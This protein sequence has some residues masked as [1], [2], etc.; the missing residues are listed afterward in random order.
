MEMIGKVKNMKSYL[1][2][3]YLLDAVNKSRGVQV[4]TFY[5]NK[6]ACLMTAPL[7]FFASLLNL[8]IGYVLLEI[9]IAEVTAVSL[10]LLGLGILFFVFLFLRMKVQVETYLLTGVYALWFIFMFAHLYQILGPSIWTF[11]CLQ[12]AFAMNRIKKIIGY[13]LSG[14][15]LG[16][17]IYFIFYPPEFAFQIGILYYLPQ[18]IAL[19]MMFI[20]LTIMHISNTSRYYSLQNQFDTL[21]RQKRDIYKLYEDVTYKEE[22]LQEQNEQLLSFM[23][24]IKKRD[25][26]L[27]NLAFYDFLTGLPNRRMFLEK[28]NQCLDEHHDGD[29]FY[30]VYIDIDSFKR[31]N[32]T[33][34]HQI[35]DD[36]IYY[37]AERLKKIIHQEDILGRLGGDEFAL[38]VKRPLSE[39]ELLAEIE[40]VRE[41]F[42]QPIAI[43]NKE[44]WS[45]ASFGISVFPRDGK[46]ASLLLRCADMSMY[47]AKELGKNK[48]EFFQPYMQEEIEAK[49]RIESH[50]LNA[51]EKNEFYLVFQ[52]QYTI[53]KEKIRGIEALLRWRSSDLG[54]IPPAQFIPIAEENRLIIP[55]GEWVLRTACEKFKNYQER[56]HLDYHISVNVSTIQ[57]TDRNFVEIVKRVLQETGLDPRYLELEITESV[58]I[59]SMKNAVQTLLD[60]KELGIKIALDDFGTVYSSLSYLETLPI[61]TLKIDQCF[62]NSLSMNTSQIKII[63][64]IINIG[65]HIGVSVIAEGVENDF[66]LQY[67]KKHDC[68][69]IQGFIYAKPL[70]EENLIDL[71]S[72]HNNKEK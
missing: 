9:P 71:F 69:Y 48:V 7:M 59:D 39:A 41:I 25:E 18:L 42:S 67:L 16:F 38:L 43:N 34:G 14:I 10:V 26:K 57:L 33:L 22:V 5:E 47:K 13:T 55:L 23:E 6:I 27:Y 28:L 4:T 3:K 63:E 53:N 35:G 19:V 56:Y 50:L 40:N 21:V 72:G 45:T 17:L 1:S 70:E 52:P 12:I 51:L 62:M 32:D 8:L 58:F 60:L 61:D 68:D 54:L 66:Q 30:V 64:E 20:I 36:Y 31:I 15:T 29:P 46:D 24:E 44:I 65:H 37:A 11:A 49:A 2:I